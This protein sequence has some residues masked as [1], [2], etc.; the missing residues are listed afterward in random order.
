MHDRLTATERRD[1]MRRIRKVD[2][3]PE[4]AV[5]RA[6][7]AAGLRFRLHRTD[8]PGSPDLVFP[9]RRT[10]LFVHGC[11]WH[12]HEGCRL[13]RQPKT[14]LEYWGPKLRRNRERDQQV[15][16]SLEELGWH[17]MTV[18]ECEIADSAMLDRRVREIADRV[19][20]KRP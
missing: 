20:V 1:H 15:G 2:T 4:L 8:L 16:A 9:G 5:R 13:S 19:M 3:K 11:F 18:W 7:H 12:Q 17:V 10:A 6:A 14:R